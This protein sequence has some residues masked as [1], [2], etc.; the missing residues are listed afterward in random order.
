MKFKELIDKYNWD[1][2]CSALR[3]LYPD[4]RKNTEGYKQVFSELQTIKP[5]E[6][7]MRIVIEG[8]LDEYDRLMTCAHEN[9]KEIKSFLRHIPI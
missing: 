4:Q 3:Q 6:T 1:D 8:V 5:V 2:V 9:Q 7:R